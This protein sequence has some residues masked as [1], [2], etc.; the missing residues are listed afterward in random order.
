MTSS[1]RPCIIPFCDRQGWAAE[2]HHAVC[3]GHQA[4]VTRP[5]SVLPE[6]MLDATISGL[7]GLPAA[8]DERRAMARAF[9][10]RRKEATTA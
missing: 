4:V 10:R 9:N 3:H 7:C 8:G 2:T 5:H 1:W 6:W